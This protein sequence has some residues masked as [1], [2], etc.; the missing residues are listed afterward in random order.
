MS[1][2]DT[3]NIYVI[4]HKPKAPLKIDLH[5]DGEEDR[6][7]DACKSEKPSN[8]IDVRLRHEELPEEAVTSEEELISITVPF[9]SDYTSIELS[10]K[11]LMSLTVK[12]PAKAACPHLEMELSCKAAQAE[13]QVLCATQDYLK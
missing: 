2:N 7:C 6:N 5:T 8:D 12:L 13:H 3:T 9:L 10:Q 11:A 4:E 1:E